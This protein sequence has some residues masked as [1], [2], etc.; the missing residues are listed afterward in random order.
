M[1][2]RPKLG[3]AIGGVVAVIAFAAIQI[4]RQSFRPQGIEA[5]AQ[6]EAM[7]VRLNV[8]GAIMIAAAALAVICGFVFVLQVVSQRRS[9]AHERPR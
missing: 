5:S 1:R 4:D 2:S 7:S 3:L 8:F 9:R 6:A